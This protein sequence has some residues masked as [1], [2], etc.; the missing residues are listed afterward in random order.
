MRGKKEILTEVDQRI[1]EPP[2]LPN[3]Q[4]HN[5]AQ[6]PAVPAPLLLTKVPNKLCPMYILLR[7][8]IEKEGLD[9][10]EQ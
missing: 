1:P 7:K 5:T 6:I 9:V 4:T 2:P 8:H 3:R 10:V